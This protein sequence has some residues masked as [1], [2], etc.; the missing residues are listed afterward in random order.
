MEFAE[1][2]E[3]EDGGFGWGFGG[4]LAAVGVL[5]LGGLLTGDDDGFADGGPLGECGVV[6]FGEAE[7]EAEVVELAF[8]MRQ[9]GVAA[10][11]WQA[12][13]VGV[14][15]RGEP[16]GLIKAINGGDKRHGVTSECWASM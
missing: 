6:D 3:G 9:A 16:A 12:G 4:D 5:V 13:E 10:A 15:I 1:F 8:D 7:G 11:I 14:V 2:G